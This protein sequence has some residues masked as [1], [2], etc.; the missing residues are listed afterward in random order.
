MG[1][2]ADPLPRPAGW[3]EILAAPPGVEV[4]VIGGEL[5]T[6]AR[7]RPEHGLAQ[8][9]LAASLAAPFG[10]GRGGPGGWWLINEPDVAFGAHDI[11]SPDIAGWR[12]ERVPEFPRARRVAVRPDWVCEVLSPSTALRDRRDKAALY[13]EAGVPWYWLVDTRARLLEAFEATGGR[14][15]R[16]GAWSEADVA[17]VP[18]F[19]AVDLFVADLFPPPPGAEGAA[20]PPGE[21]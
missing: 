8:V 3:A 1:A 16:L 13:L 5:W 17:R 20:A 9:F 11:V 21:R 10:K 18:P 12:R 14:W 2:M 19:D 4:E 7:P 15:L 6:H